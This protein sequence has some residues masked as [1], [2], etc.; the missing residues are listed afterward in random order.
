MIIDTFIFYNEFDLLEVR[1]EELYPVVDQFILVESTHT[2]SGLPKPLYFDENRSRFEKYTDKIVHVI[3]RA[4]EVSSDG[5]PI[6]NTRSWINEKGQRMEIFNHISEYD[7]EDVI[8]ISDLDEIPNRESVLSLNFQ[9]FPVA[10]S[11]DFFYYDYTSF[12]GKWSGTK[13]FKKS[14][15]TDKSVIDN[16]RKALTPVQASA[17]GYNLIEAGWHLSYFFD[18]DGIETKIKSFAHQEF[19]SDGVLSK[20]KQAVFEKKDLFDRAWERIIYKPYGEH[21]PELIKDRVKNSYLDDAVIGI[22][23]HR[24]NHL[25]RLLASMQDWKYQKIITVQPKRVAANLSD[26]WNLCKST[27]K[28][29]VVLM[30]DDIEVL[31]QDAIY[32]GIQILQMTGWAICSTHET[33]NSNYELGKH[34]F[35]VYEKEWLPGYFLIIDTHKIGDYVFDT[36]LNEDQDHVDLDMCMY[37][38]SLG[39][40]VGNIDRVIVH[41]SDNH[42]PEHLNRGLDQYNMAH[43]NLRR[44][45]SIESTLVPD[46]SVYEATYIK[47][48]N[49]YSTLT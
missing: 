35:M 14:Q 24:K 26:V 2:H 10:F 23:T 38:H 8:M 22:A 18:L 41:H 25:D 34:L 36:T 28:R 16:T 15:I 49:V 7:P 39:Y 1:L 12:K 4:E 30:D 6:A 31:E 43:G 29:Y 46:K 42:F 44:K 37:A 27:G 33:Y 13:A 3:H 40:R 5:N 9:N 21:L 20:I 48:K 45:W 11:Q 32:R 19:N 47:H 17:Q